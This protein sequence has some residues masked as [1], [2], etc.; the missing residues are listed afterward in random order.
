MSDYSLELACGCINFC[1]CEQRRAR[2][3]AAE[4]GFKAVNFRVSHELYECQECQGLV[5]DYKKH[6]AW[7][8]DIMNK[9]VHFV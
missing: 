1:K 3:Q 8:H 9:L 5:A 6:K 2:E 4:L 7:H